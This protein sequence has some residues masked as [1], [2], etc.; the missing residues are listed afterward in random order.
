MTGEADPQHL[1]IPSPPFYSNLVTV[2]IILL[3]SILFQAMIEWQQC[4]SS[5]NRTETYRIG[6]AL[7]NK[8]RFWHK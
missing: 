5:S 4:G 1:Q 8:L 2:A 7:K 6:Q 3:R